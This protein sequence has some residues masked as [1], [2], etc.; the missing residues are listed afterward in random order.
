MRRLALGTV[1]ALGLAVVVIMLTTPRPAEASIHE[2]IAALCRAG[3]EEV[4]PFGQNKDGESFLRA[5]MATGFITSIE[6]TA[7]T[8]TINFDPT[9]PNSKFRSTGG[10]V[11]FTSPTGVLVTLNPGVEPDPAF[12]AHAVCNNLR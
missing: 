4:V 5:L 1:V 6:S 7:T 10:Q 11:S 2:I 9:V 12:P 8:L 3:G